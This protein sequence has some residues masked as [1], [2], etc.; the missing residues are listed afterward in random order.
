MNLFRFFSNILMIS[1]LSL[2]A[3]TSYGQERK[4]LEMEDIFRGM[5]FSQ[6]SVYG[7]NWMKDRD[8][9]SSL[10]RGNDNNFVIKYSISTGQAVDTLV[11]GRILASLHQGGNFRFS[12]Y[13][14]SADEKKVLLTT[15]TERIYRRSSKSNYYIYDIEK[16]ELKPLAAGAK[17]SYASF[18]PDASK[19]AFFRENNLFYTDLKT[20][21]EVA[22]TKDGKWN[23]LI[24]GAADWVYEEEFSFAKAFE[25]SP[26]SKKIAFIS[27]DES[28]VKEFNMQMW[29]P[30]YPKDYKFKYPKAGEDNSHVLVS[31]FH[32]DGANTTS[33]DIGKEKDQYIP[34]ISWTQN[35]DLLSV[36]RMN[37]LQNKLEILHADA[38]TGQSRVILTE[39][40]GTYV[41]LDFNDDLR[42][43]ANGKQFLYTSERDGFKHLYLYD[44]SGKLIRQI[45]SG[46][47]EIGSIAA[48][49]EKKSLIYYTST[50]VSSLERHLYVIGMNG[51]GKKRL[52]MEAGSH[53]A[54]FNANVQFFINY[55][56][57]SDSPLK[58]TLH[59]APSGKL[60]RVLE[61]NQRLRDNLSSFALGK[62]E[63]TTVK[64]ANGEDLNAYLIKPA[65]F[66]PSKKYPVLMY[67]YGGPGS[68][69]VLNR[70]GGSRDLW[71]HYLAQEG[72]IVA[73]VDNR[74]TGGKGRDFK[75]VTY[76]NL[77]KYETE[78]QIA[79]AKY[80]AGLDYIDSERIGI[81]GW[82]YGG[83][84]SSLAIMLG[85]EVFKA[86]I[87]VAPV[88]TWRY[89]DT[90]YTERYLQTPQL[91]AAGYDD[92]SPLTHV[93][94]LKGKY[95]LIHGTADDNV[96]FQNA[97]ALQD[98]L[99]EANKQ[100]ESF[101]YPN[102]NHGIYG[103]NTT[104]HLYTMMTNFLINNL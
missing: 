6:N 21:E 29:G 85:N 12:D 80:L 94:K 88:T 14:L 93:K 40:S 52:S 81:W 32:L 17:Q 95:L 56:S 39:E 71:F 2:Y 99:I 97:V 4:R 43:L 8:Y 41:D 53:N 27:F 79:A 63:F 90:I 55:H 20:G 62:K 60:L 48:V 102:K 33:V 57:S 28:N 92:N 86:A 30:L 68:Q 87:A 91:N 1:V 7:V 38:K 104:M 50:E 26:D 58:V 23:H 45:T 49:D 22:I 35:P 19:V 78:D 65:D 13:E 89:Y 76:K 24:H 100:F 16:A 83:Y 75:H 61:D 47:W 73:C 44:I 82:S 96:H 42:Y 69:Q 66:D 31:I 70:W 84:M 64:A 72:F 15:E 46:N 36:I 59:E 51:K 25:W 34:R 9:Y 67:V 101:Y 3:L 98:A 74:G 37:R 54:N 77:G 103:G 18:S 11:D 5:T 10:V